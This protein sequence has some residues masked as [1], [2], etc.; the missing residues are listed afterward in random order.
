VAQAE[1]RAAIPATLDG[2]LRQVLREVVRE[3]I[4]AIAEAVVGALRAESAA[5]PASADQTP[6][7]ITVADAA[8]Q[9]GA[10]EKWVRGL[11]RSGHLRALAVGRVLRISRGELR[12]FAT[13]TAATNGGETTDTEALAAGI[14][15]KRKR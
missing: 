10:S 1:G 5:V 4:P 7:Y 2:V 15:A 14:L 3:Q 6:Q 8:A 9:L 11:I 12:R 13:T